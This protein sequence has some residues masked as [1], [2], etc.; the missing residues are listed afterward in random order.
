MNPV[1]FFRASRCGCLTA[2]I[3]V[4]SVWTAMRCIRSK[5]ENRVIDNMSIKCMEFAPYYRMHLIGNF[6][7]GS[8]HEGDVQG[9][10]IKVVGNYLYGRLFA[11]V[12]AVTIRKS[13]IDP[14]IVK[15]LSGLS[16]LESV[17]FIECKITPHEVESLL[18]CR[19]SINEVYLWEC[20][21]SRSEAFLLKERYPKIVFNCK[22]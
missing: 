2:L 13:I 12:K 17:S 15:L 1:S 5:I 11:T 6:M 8:S 19:S 18:S 22:L 14:E 20:N 16:N 7:Y 3:I 10:L 9:L 21:I 4:V